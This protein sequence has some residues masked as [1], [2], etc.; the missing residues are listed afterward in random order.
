MSSLPSDRSRRAREIEWEKK[1]YEDML[2]YIN[3]ADY[4]KYGGAFEEI[5]ITEIKSDK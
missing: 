4:V 3:Y 2:Y 1:Q 5:K